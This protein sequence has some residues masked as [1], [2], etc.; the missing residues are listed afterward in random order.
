MTKFI[1]GLAL[2]LTINSSVTAQCEKKIVLNSSKTE[3]L[4]ASFTVQR[5]VDE[6][7]VI[8]IINK[9]ITI[10]PGGSDNQMSGTINS[11]SCNWKTPWKEGKMVLN[12]TLVDPRGEAQNVKITIEGKE[13]KISL[14]AEI[15][16][17]P[18]R[19]VRV[20]A[21]KFEEKK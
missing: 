9:E 11:D 6:V 7:T 12:T 14:L 18:D 8:E 13:G 20:F 17:N 1:L 3:Y 4:D 21:D 19:K 5:T 15:V 10:T 2:L 16:D